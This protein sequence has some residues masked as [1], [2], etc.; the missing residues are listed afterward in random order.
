MKNKEIKNKLFNIRLGMKLFLLDYVES[1]IL[2][3]IPILKE[4]NIKSNNLKTLECYRN[5]DNYYIIDDIKLLLSNVD[6]Y[7]F[8]QKNCI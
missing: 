2:N 6:I 4:L 3:I 1:S 7:N 5:K 8:L